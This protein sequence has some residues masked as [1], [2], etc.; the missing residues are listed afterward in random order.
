M[1]RSF[2]QDSKSI[3]FVINSLE[4]NHNL[5]AWESDFIKSIKQHYITENKFLSD[6]QLDKL[7][8]L[9]EKY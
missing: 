4:S 8:D 5:N 6:K 7:S 3:S 2:N 9:W 1:I